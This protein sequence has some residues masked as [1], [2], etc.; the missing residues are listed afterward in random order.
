MNLIFFFLINVIRRSNYYIIVIHKFLLYFFS[1]K[2]LLADTPFTLDGIVIVSSYT[3]KKKSQRW[4]RI[5]TNRSNSKSWLFPPLSITTFILDP[6]HLKT[7]FTS[8][9]HSLQKTLRI[10]LSTFHSHQSFLFL[11]SFCVFDFAFCFGRNWFDLNRR[12]GVPPQTPL[13]HVTDY[14]LLHSGCFMKMN[15]DF[16]IC[17]FASLKYICMFLKLVSFSY[18][19][20][21]VSY[22]LISVSA[23]V[24]NRASGPMKHGHSLD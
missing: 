8:F 17:I 15:L 2:F 14:Q 11:R 20:L 13:S 9:L 3:R 1:S 6:I 16:L 18:P 23:R 21:Y 7:L 10:S 12:W 22:L 24:H 5:I 4:T 19:I